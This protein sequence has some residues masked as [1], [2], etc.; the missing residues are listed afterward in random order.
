MQVAKAV[1]LTHIDGAESRFDHHRHR[2]RKPSVV[3]LVVTERGELGTSTSNQ[4]ATVT[5][6]TT[7]LS[8][9]AGPNIFVTTPAPHA[10][11]TD[12]GSNGTN[13]PTAQTTALNSVANGYNADKLIVGVDFGTTYSGYGENDSCWIKN[14]ADLSLQS[15]S[16]VQRDPGRH[17]H[18]QNV[19]MFPHPDNKKG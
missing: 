17:R 1:V 12:S 8:L 11:S 16:S 4:Q 3:R 5:N 2:D 6:N 18:N 14:Q 7:T 10:M 19:A 15:G 9:M 13:T